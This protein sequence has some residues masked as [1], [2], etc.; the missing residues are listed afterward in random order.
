MILSDLKAYLRDHGQASLPAMARHFEADA[1]VLRGMLD[2]WV[3][4]GTV[5]L[6]PPEGHCDGCTACHTR[7]D[8][9][10]EW[11]AAPSAGHG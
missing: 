3:G 9:I 6:R 11:A 10:Y 1:E 5:R 2:V 7:C 8:E 4:K